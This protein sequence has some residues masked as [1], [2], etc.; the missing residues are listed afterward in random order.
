MLFALRDE[1]WRCEMVGLDYSQASVR[2][3]RQIQDA[4][5]REAQ[6]E[7]DEHGQDHDDD[8]RFLQC[9]VLESDVDGALV[10]AFNIVLDKGTFDAVSLSNEAVD[11]RGRRGCEVY[12]ERI[13]RLMKPDAFLV[14]V[15]CNWTEDELVSWFT[16]YGARE[17]GLKVH[18]KAH[19]P[20]FEFGGQ[21]GQTVSCVCFQKADAG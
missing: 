6:S 13:A 4:R 21:K 9:D 3:A 11:E 2:L 5:R 10:D 8:I 19:F 1:G 20:S 18:G 16:G 14:V 17:A 15:S 7:H 12:A